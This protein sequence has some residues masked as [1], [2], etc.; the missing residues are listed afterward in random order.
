MPHT[1]VVVRQNPDPSS[2]LW[3]YFQELKVNIKVSGSPEAA[4]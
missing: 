3:K 4:S 1:P 2:V